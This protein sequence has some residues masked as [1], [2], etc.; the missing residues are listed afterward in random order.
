MATRSTHCT[1]HKGLSLLLPLGVSAPPP[2]SV[3]PPSSGRATTGP[4]P[5]TAGLADALNFLLCPKG[6]LHKP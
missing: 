3:Q 1:A 4:R 5:A 2:A 6:G